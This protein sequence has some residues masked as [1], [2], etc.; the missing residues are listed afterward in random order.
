MTG[1]V[2]L[3]EGKS[4]R[5]ETGF[6]VERERSRR[7][8]RDRLQEKGYFGST[9]VPVSPRLLHSPLK[10]A[11]LLEILNALTLVLAS[12]ASL[13]ES[14]ALLVRSSSMTV[15]RYAFSKLSVSLHR[16]LSLEQS[17]REMR[18]LFPDFFIAIV[19]LSEKTGN[20]T[21]GFQSLSAF[22]C[23]QEMRKRTMEKALQYPK[24]VF[25]LTVLLALGIV[26]FIVPMFAN[27][28][29]LFQE[30]LPFLTRGLVYVSQTVRHH[31]VPI[32]IGASLFTVWLHTPKLNRLHPFF[33][34]SRLVRGFFR[35]REDRMLYAHGMQ[36][37]LESGQTVRDATRIAGSCLADRNKRHG[38]TVADML[39]SGATFSQAFVRVSWFPPIF[40]VYIGPAEKAGVLDIG[41]KQIF[42][43]IE[44]K[45]AEHF[46]KFG[47]LVE[48]LLILI[49]GGIV[50][51]LLLAVYLPIFDL[52]NR[53][54]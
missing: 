49:V 28:Y 2:F 25:Y 41:F 42:Q 54:G 13:R 10:T 11:Q 1:T 3:W 35:S 37:L 47:K 48:P 45:N 5:G 29:A 17:F 26:L 18:P 36:I 52:G 20:L 9:I 16:G 50:L 19:S 6:G 27:V 51:A 21:G 44:R 34:V 23:S 24:T 43:F 33:G 8:V 22:Y 38:S 32:G 30:D 7:R 12:G 14:L 31:W 4:L 53:I 40:H 15:A 39:D 46:E